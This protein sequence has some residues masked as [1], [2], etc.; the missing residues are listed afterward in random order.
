MPVLENA[1]CYEENEGELRRVRSLFERTTTGTSLIVDNGGALKGPTHP[2]L[3]FRA[4]AE[5]SLKPWALIRVPIPVST[6][7]YLLL[8]RGR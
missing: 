3:L 5:T 1:E 7:S 2:T 8:G 4:G 6:R